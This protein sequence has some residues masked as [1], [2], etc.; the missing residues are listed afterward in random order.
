[1]RD[2]TRSES[3]SV[4]FACS[5]RLYS[6]CSFRSYRMSAS[7][8]TRTPRP[9]GAGTSR[10]RSAS[11]VMSSRRVARWR[12]G[13]ERVRVDAHFGKAFRDAS[14]AFGTHD[15]P[16]AQPSPFPCQ[17]WI[18]PTPLDVRR[19]PRWIPR[20]VSSS[21]EGGLGR[22]GFRDEINEYDFQRRRPVAWDG[23]HETPMR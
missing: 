22:S 9:T 1:M 3:C 12:Q 13:I 19:P 17:T 23:D 2:I 4:T 7:R 8:C 16:S 18:R 5:I 10:V 11:I 20:F 14:K 15:G 6:W 21:R